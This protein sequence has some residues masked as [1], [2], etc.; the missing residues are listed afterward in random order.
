MPRYPNDE[1]LMNDEIVHPVITRRKRW[2]CCNCSKKDI[3]IMSST[4][5]C[6]LFVMCSLTT[7]N[8][9]FIKKEDGSL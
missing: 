2:N 5:L 6:I 9:Y 7:L 8:V 3:C 1:S 4:L